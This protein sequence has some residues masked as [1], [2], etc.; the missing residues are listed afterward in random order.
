MH[1]L[2]RHRRELCT[3]KQCLRCTIRHW[4]PPQLYRWSGFMES[5]LRH[6]DAFIAMSQFSRQKHRE[7]GFEPDMHVLPDFVADPEPRTSTSTGSPHARPYFLFV[8]RLEKIK[9]LDDVIPVFKS[10]PEADLL[11]VG[12]GKHETELRRLAQ[13]TERI[14]FVGAMSPDALRSHYQHAIA[15]IVPSVCFETFGMVLIEAFQNHVP[16]IA[17]RLGP[18]PE[19]IESSN[20]GELFETPDQLVAAMRRIQ[21]D[22]AYRTKLA[23]AGYRAYVEQYCE[24]A[25]LPRFLDIVRSAALR[26]GRP[27]LAEAL[28]QVEDAARAR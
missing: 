2:W 9:G 11:V 7:F 6:V 4:R 26:A 12:Q 14:R 15:V 5:Q 23:D 28:S 19:I 21:S 22:P 3:G 17:R 16:V 8:G 24:S 10:Y 27:H 18:F 13:G 25:V 1:V 20:G